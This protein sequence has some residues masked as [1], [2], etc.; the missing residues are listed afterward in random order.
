[1]SPLNG[2]TTSKPCFCAAR[3][4]GRDGFDFL[5]AKF[6]AFAG[7]RIQAGDGDFRARQTEVAAGL[8]GE[9]DGERDFFRRQFFGNGFD[10]NV[11]GGQRD[12]QPA[13]AFVRAEQHHRGAF[14][15][16]EFGKKFRLADEFVSGAD[17][18]FLVDRRGDERVQFAAQTALRAVAQPGDDGV[19]GGRRTGGQ[20]FPATVRRQRID[21]EKSVRRRRSWKIFSAAD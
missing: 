10:G 8:R 17:D 2:P 19:G 12:A 16:G 7:V 20:D 4:V 11:N 6:P 5:V 15:A 14:G 1:M 21:D 9:F 3:T 18:G 13:S